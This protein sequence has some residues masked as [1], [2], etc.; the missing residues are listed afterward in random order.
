MFRLIIFCLHTHSVAHTT[1]STSLVLLIDFICS[2]NWIRFHLRP[3]MVRT[4]YFV[5]FCASLLLSRCG[6][7]SMKFIYCGMN[8]SMEST[9]Q[10]SCHAKV[11][12]IGCLR[13]ICHICALNTK[14][15]K[16]QSRNMTNRVLAVERARGQKPNTQQVVHSST[17]Q[18][19]KNRQK[20]TARIR[21]QIH[22]ITIPMPTRYDKN[23]LSS[24][25]RFAKGGG[26]I[27]CRCRCWTC[28]TLLLSR[29]WMRQ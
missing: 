9:I 13:R 16:I 1:I 2:S 7:I 17:R 8:T 25:F 11:K 22:F 27:L 19:N 4:L 29:A 20:Q 14:N 26:G 18:L 10:F 23:V 12:T 5:L 24:L 28:F 15:H 21:R 6:V 3:F